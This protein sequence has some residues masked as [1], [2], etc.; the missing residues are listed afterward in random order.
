VWQLLHNFVPFRSML[1]HRG[2]STFEMWLICEVAEED[3]INGLF[4]CSCVVQVWCKCLYINVSP[5]PFASSYSFL[6]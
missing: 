1:K 6:A 4:T 2:L 5:H 3:W